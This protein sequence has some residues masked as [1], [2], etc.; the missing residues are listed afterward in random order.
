MRKRRRGAP[1][2]QAI[3]ALLPLK[4]GHLCIRL[5]DDDLR[6]RH[7]AGMLVRHR[8]AGRRALLRR[9]IPSLRLFTCLLRVFSACAGVRR[10]MGGSCWAELREN[11]LPGG[12]GMPAL[13]SPST[14]MFCLRQKFVSPEGAAV[15]AGNSACLLRA[16]IMWKKDRAVRRHS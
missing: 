10:S 1:C 13:Y 9:L 6:V 14:R 7:S 8:H 2:R 5:R 4:N 16:S 15:P 11:T 12:G 3:D